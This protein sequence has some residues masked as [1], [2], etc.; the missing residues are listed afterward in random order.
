MSRASSGLGNSRLSCRKSFKISR[1]VVE[2]ALC[3]TLSMAV[4]SI[5]EARQCGGRTVEEA[6]WDTREEAATREATHS[7]L[8]LALVP[9]SAVEEVVGGHAEGARHRFLAARVQLHT[10]HYRPPHHFHEIHSRLS[11]ATTHGESP[12]SSRRVALQLKP[13]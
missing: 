9:A 11:V 2:L 3:S 6:Y 13:T 12:K 7:N 1:A 4:F 10:V 5:W 8:V